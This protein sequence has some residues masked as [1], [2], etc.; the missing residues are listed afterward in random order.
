[1]TM[2]KVREIISNAVTLDALK[3]WLNITTDDFD[4]KLRICLA[5]AVSEAETYTGLTLARSRYTVALPFAPVMDTAIHHICS[6]EAV[7]VDGEL[8]DINDV[9]LDGDAVCVYGVGG[10]TAELTIIAGPEVL[11]PDIRGAILMIASAHFNSPTDTV[12][13]L[14]K[15]STHLLNPYRYYNA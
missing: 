10:N 6:V 7:K 5:A 8:V 14:P 4:D 9:S 1:M 2:R 11:E 13:N 3:V 12:E 15:A